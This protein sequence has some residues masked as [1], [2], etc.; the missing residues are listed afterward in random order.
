[1]SDSIY[2]YLDLTYLGEEKEKALICFENAKKLHPAAVCISPPFVSMAKKALNCPIVSVVNFPSGERPIEQVLEAI[3]TLLDND[4]DEIDI[5]FP[6]QT[7][8]N[9]KEEEAFTRLASYL[10]AIPSHIIKKVIIETGQLK[11]TH[12]I[13]RLCERLTTYNIDFIK[14]STGKTP[15]GATLES[16]KVILSV[17]QNTSIGLKVSGGIRTMEQANAFFTLA[18][19]Y[20]QDQPIKATQF[21][22]GASQI[23]V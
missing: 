3:H 4:I 20:Y 2:H 1:M 13:K 22:I 14:T 18:Q 7:Y 23:H 10:E 8:L 11:E 17:I 19:S 6:Y 9:G 12:T 16:V 15:V 21:R 5:V